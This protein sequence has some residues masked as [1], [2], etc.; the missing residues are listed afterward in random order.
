LQQLV[1][2]CRT[3]SCFDVASPSPDN[4]WMLGEEGNIACGGDDDVC[5]KAAPY[6]MAVEITIGKKCGI[7]SFI[8]ATKYCPGNPGAKVPPLSAF[9]PPPL[10]QRISHSLSNV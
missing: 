6:I 9:L 5:A 8:R 7:F 2:P 10:I 4:S 1:A 3:G